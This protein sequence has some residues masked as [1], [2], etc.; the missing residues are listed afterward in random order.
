MSADLTIIST[1][2]FA[3]AP[4]AIFEAFA[5]PARLAR[6]W[7]PAGF[8]NTIVEF[9]FNAGGKWS[10]IMRAPDGSEFPNDAE[11]REI[12]PS[13][14]IAFAHAPPHPFVMTIDLVREGSGTQMTM[15]MTHES[16]EDCDRV[17]PFVVPGNE[18]NFDRLVVELARS[19]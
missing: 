1:R 15:Q 5:D 19:A 12:T 4:E 13:R 18:E 10:T 2:W 8:S 6:W 16:A 14:R 9:E 17:R 7:G 3:F 11:F